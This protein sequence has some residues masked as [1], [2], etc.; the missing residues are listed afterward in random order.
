MIGN[1][2]K[3]KKFNSNGE[4]CLITPREESLLAQALQNSF[5]LANTAPEL[6][7]VVL[8]MNERIIQ[9]RERIGNTISNALKIVESVR[10]IAE[11]AQ[12]ERQICREVCEST[13]SFGKSLDSLGEEIVSVEKVLQSI[14][15]FV[16][17]VFSKIKGALKIIEIIESIAEQIKLLSLNTSIEAARQSSNGEVFSVIAQEIGKLSMK[18][19]NE[20]TF[21][22]KALIEIYKDFEGLLKMIQGAKEANKLV[23][24]TSANVRTHLESILES[25]KVLLKQSEDVLSSTVFLEKLSSD[26]SSSMQEAAKS[27]E[28]DESVIAEI[29]KKGEL[30]TKLSEAQILSIGKMKLSLYSTSSI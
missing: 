9:R 23:S 6:E 12:K 24:E 17:T 25:M 29:R 11:S 4:T 28:D 30:V 22:S 18:T 16:E 21:V 2:V 8:E 26:I 19:F 13:A 20:S 1:I 27:L 5:E 3:K 7:R 14:D 15:D 10:T